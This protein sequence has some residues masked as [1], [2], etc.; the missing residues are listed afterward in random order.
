MSSGLRFELARRRR[1]QHALE[2]LRRVDRRVADHEGDARR[3]GAVVLRHHVAVAG[4]HA[5]AREIEA[6]HLAHALRQDG[7]RALPDIGGAREHH[8]RAV[9][10]ELDLDGGVRLAGPV[11]RLGGAADVMRAGKAETFTYALALRQLALARGPAALALDPV[12]AFRQAVARHHEIVVGEGRRDE[13][14]GAPHRQRIEAELGR[15]LVEQAL[16]GEADV[17]RAVAAEGAAGRRVGERAPA[18]VLD[19]VQVVDGVEHRAGIEDRHHAVAR[20]GAAALVAFALD[21]GD[22]AVAAQTELEP[23]VGLG[24]AAMG[25]EGLLAV[26]HHAHGAAGTAR[27]QRGDQL[28]VEGLGAAAEAAADMRLDHADARHVHVE[29]LRQHQVHVIRHLG[30]GMHGHAVALDVVVGDRG[31]H[32]HLVLADLGAVV[33]PFA[34][35]VGFGETLLDIAKLEQHVALDVVGLALVQGGGARRHRLLAGVIG[36]Q[37]AHPKLDQLD[38]LLGDGVV[39]GGDGGDRLAAIAHL[40]ARQGMLAARDRQHAEGL[41]AVGASD[42]RLHARQPQ[43]LGDIDLEDLGVRIGAAVNS[44]G[45]HSGRNEIGGVLRAARHLLGAVDH[46]HVG[47]DGA[48]RH[49]LVHGATPAA[50]SSAA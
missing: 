14:I 41:V 1:H 18:D 40:V 4:D 35:Q 19:V 38:R 22:A 17:D 28:D 29:D 31:V 25:D 5:D 24:P 48:G 44:P 43:R 37:L 46:R 32:L 33:A 2:V 36:G 30:A 27:Q 12:D 9:E 45:E 34:H 23:D 49:D 16:E 50:L 7:G 47:A 42:D 21:R 3:I 39:D 6:E 15:H 8:H 26:H 11:H 20:M 13:I 10:V